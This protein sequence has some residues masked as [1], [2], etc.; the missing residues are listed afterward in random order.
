MTNKPTGLSG[1][2]GAHLANLGSE[3][4]GDALELQ[5]GDQTPVDLWLHGF[6]AKGQV[7]CQHAR[8]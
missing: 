2:L 3:T 8:A 5:Y 7:Q 1:P 4:L 6:V